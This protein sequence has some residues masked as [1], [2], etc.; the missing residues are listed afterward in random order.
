M[1]TPS[2]SILFAPFSFTLS[3]YFFLICISIWKQTIPANW[4]VQCNTHHIEV[5]EQNETKHCKKGS[6]WKWIFRFKPLERQNL[7]LCILI[8][9]QWLIVWYFYRIS[10]WNIVGLKSKKIFY[11]S[12]VWSKKR[13]VVAA[14]FRT[15]DIC[16]F[17]CVGERLAR[18]LHS[19]IPLRNNDD[20]SHLWCTAKQFQPSTLLLLPRTLVGC[21][22]LL[23]FC[24]NL[25]LNWFFSSSISLLK[26]YLFLLIIRV[27]LL[28]SDFCPS[29]ICGFW[30]RFLLFSSYNRNNNSE[31]ESEREKRHYFQLISVL[32][33]C[34]VLCE[35][36]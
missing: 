19:F 18:P 28:H 22:L 1:N 5:Q 30:I 34:W 11:L 6:K 33:L 23:P 10:W 16:N 24:S 9:L 26:Y 35:C 25:N 32:D 14:F 4:G 15:G 8:V 20:Q 31:S 17:I 21:V 13:F 12:F 27:M 3:R 29:G 36:I 7:A 2:R